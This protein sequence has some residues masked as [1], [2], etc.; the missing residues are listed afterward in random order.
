MD[1]KEGFEAQG[2]GQFLTLEFALQNPKISL[3]LLMPVEAIKVRYY[4]GW[5][6]EST[7]LTKL[8]GPFSLH[9]TL[10]SLWLN[11]IIS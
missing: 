5:S 1:E 9:E 7:Y 4:S 11:P 3:M 2:C 6:F 8:T 10:D